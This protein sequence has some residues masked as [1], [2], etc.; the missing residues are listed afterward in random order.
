MMVNVRPEGRV[1]VRFGTS[2]GTVAVVEAN[3]CRTVCQ[4]WHAHI[5][6]GRAHLEEVPCRTHV[7]KILLD[8]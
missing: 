4:W 7:G 3:R 6:G 2:S 5:P 1:R 8:L